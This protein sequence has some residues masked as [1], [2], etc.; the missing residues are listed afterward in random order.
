M[1]NRINLLGII[2]I[3]AIIGLGFTACNDGSSSTTVTVAVTG[4]TVAPTTLDLT[5]GGSTGTLTP[6]IAP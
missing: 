5:V 1:K 3:I 2:A 6:K 4:V